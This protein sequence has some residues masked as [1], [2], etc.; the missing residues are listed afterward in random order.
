MLIMAVLR[1]L[2]YADTNL[3]K[4]KWLKTELRG[5]AQHLAGKTVG[6]VGIGNIGKNLAKLLKGFECKVHYYDVNRLPS[7]VESVLGIS[8][9]PLHELLKTSDVITLH[10]PLTPETANMIN[11]NTLAMMDR[12][13]IL[14]N[15]AR[16][17][18]VDEK[19][20][21][22]ALQTGVIAGAGL[23]VFLTEPLEASNPL[24]AMDN[25][26]LSPHVAG[27]TLNNMSIR[28]S[29]IAKNLAAFLNGRDIAKEDIIL[30]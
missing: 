25:V 4:G 16:G 10:A 15:A 6:I 24:L 9:K 1:R 22:E 18:L 30:G 11:A 28:A 27:S 21:I 14:V 12:S 29:R 5:E 8:Y 23:D 20:L 13:A 19:A 2:V 7:D 26:V 3:R 17:G